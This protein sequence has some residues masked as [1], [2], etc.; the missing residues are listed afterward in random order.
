MK[1]LITLLLLIF[2]AV[3]SFS[4]AAQWPPET[5]AKVPG[6]ALEYPT[7]LSAVNQSL[8]QMLNQGGKIISS[9]LASDGPVVT[10]RFHQH[11]I[12]CL[13]KGAGSGSDQNVPTSKCYAMN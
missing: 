11:Y 2:V 12:I 8:E 4:A 10:L 5:G 1:N 9:S 3:S 13:L 6:N 7:R